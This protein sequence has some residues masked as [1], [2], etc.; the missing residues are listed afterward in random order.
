M[1]KKDEMTE[2]KVIAYHSEN[3]PQQISGLLHST[4][5]W[6]GVTIGQ[7]GDSTYQVKLADGESAYLKVRFSLEPDSFD[8]E[9]CVLNY[10]RGKVTVPHPIAVGQNGNLHFL[11]NSK[12]FGSNAANLFGKLQDEDIVRILAD[13]LNQ[14]HSI[15][16]KSC[17]SISTS[18]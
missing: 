13:S 2:D 7:S 12:V 14:L 15:D 17:R 10:L 3:L 18:M 5:P 9:V 8:Y 4:H 11:L 16:S 1:T 6:T